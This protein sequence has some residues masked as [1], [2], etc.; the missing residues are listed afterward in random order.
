MIIR[1]GIVLNN[2]TTV[3]TGSISI[4]NGE[5]VTNSTSVTLNLTATDG[6][7]ITGYYVSTS[8]HIPSAS[9]S[10]WVKVLPTT[11]YSADVS[12]DLSGGD[13]AKTVYVWYKDASDNISATY[14]YM[15][16]LITYVARQQIINLTVISGQAYEIVENGLQ[17]RALVYNDRSYT[18]SKVPSWLVG[19]TYIKTAN[20]DK[21]SSAISYLTFGV[22]HDVI[23]YVA[24]DNRITAKPHWLVSSFTDTGNDLVIMDTTLSIYESNFLAGTVTLGGNEGG[25]RYSMYTVIIVGQ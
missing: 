15:I 8:P 13:G 10:G 24:H 19:A 20:N 23:V 5:I 7:E 1:Q 18:Y 6:V 16:T 21:A 11:N 12:Y 17:N 25:D 4:N 3:P 22:K 9:G 2:G 14:S